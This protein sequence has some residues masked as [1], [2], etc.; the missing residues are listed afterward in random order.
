MLRMAR[1]AKRTPEVLEIVLERILQGEYA[2]EPLPSTRDLAAELGVSK[3][4]VL[5]AYREAEARGAVKLAGG[6]R[7]AVPKGKRPLEAVFAVPAADTP[8]SFLWFASLDAVVAK[9]GGRATLVDYDGPSD[10]RLLKALQGRF[11]VFFLNPPGQISAVLGRLLDKRQHRVVSL[12]SDL[13]EWDI[14]GVD[15]MPAAAVDL[16][17]FHL[18]AKGAREIHLVGSQSLRGRQAQL[19]ER[20]A[21]RLGA[22]GARGERF[23]PEKEGTNLPKAG[24]LQAKRL[25]AVCP[26]PVAV[27]FA[28]L[29]AAIGGYRAFWEAGLLPGRDVLA[30]CLSCEPEPPYFTPSLT[31]IVA[32]SRTSVLEEAIDQILE[33]KIDERRA[34]VERVLPRARLYDGES[35]GANVPLPD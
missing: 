15:N 6:R 12:Y 25:L 20:W 30:A 22:V 8:N 5:R 1:P 26:R 32:P 24:A 18:A 17:I 21:D 13:P 23:F 33:K 19:A 35:T 34:W 16:L 11:D 7:L 29:P 2:K 3:F 14:W 9:R 10:S 4:T 27:I 28:D 31:S